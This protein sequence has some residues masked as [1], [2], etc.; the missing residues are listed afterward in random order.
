MQHERWLWLAFVAGIKLIVSF[1]VL[2]FIHPFIHFA[3]GSRLRKHTHEHKSHEFVLI[4]IAEAFACVSTWSE[5]CWQQF[6]VIEKKEQ[7]KGMKR[8][9][10][11]GVC[12]CSSCFTPFENSQVWKIRR[13]WEVRTSE[14]KFR[15]KWKPVEVACIVHSTIWVRVELQSVRVRCGSRHISEWNNH[16]Y[17][18]TKKTRFNI[19][20]KWL[21]VEIWMKIQLKGLKT[22]PNMTLK[23]ASQ[24]RVKFRLYRR[25]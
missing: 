19:F 15:R 5:Y 22:R 9:T 12:S 4:L 8:T 2:A 18:R 3:H 7:T 6:D 11:R 14:R 13:Q 25:K 20:H 1:N 16:N 21:P 17:V 24:K 10:S 23:I